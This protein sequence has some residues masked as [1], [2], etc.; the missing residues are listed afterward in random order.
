MKDKNLGLTTVDCDPIKNTKRK[1]FQTS[2]FT[3]KVAYVIFLWHKHTDQAN[4]FFIHSKQR[5][6]V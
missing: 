4:Q 5:K 3:G 1:I 6:V 2:I